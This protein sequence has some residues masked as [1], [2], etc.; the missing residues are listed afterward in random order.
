MRAESLRD[1]AFAAERARMTEDARAVAVEMLIEG[2]TI[3][4][5]LEESRERC[6]AVF[7]RP[8]AKVLAVEFDKIEGAQ[9]GSIVA[10]GR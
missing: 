4:N 2:N 7:Q 8:P 10:G 6:L 5:V 1:D 3:A 9:D